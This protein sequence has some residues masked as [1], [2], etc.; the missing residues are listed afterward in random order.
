D[1]IAPVV[2]FEPEPAPQ[3]TALTGRQGTSISIPATPEAL[4][5]YLRS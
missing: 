2:G 5:D 4:E 1:V 3:L